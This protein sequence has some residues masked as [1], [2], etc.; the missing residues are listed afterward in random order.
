[1]DAYNK[2][3]EYIDV[4]GVL[5]PIKT[6]FRQSILFESIINDFSLE[7]KD[8][9][10]KALEVY[11]DLLPKG[12]DLNELIEKILWFFNGGKIYESSGSENNKAKFCDFNQDANY[13]VT[14]FLQAYGIDLSTENMHWWRFLSL[15]EGLPE[16]TQYSKIL[17][18]RCM[19]ITKEMSKEQKKHY[20]KMKR[21][22]RLKDTRPQWMID[23]EFSEGFL[24]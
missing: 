15:V 18:Y 9:I 6:D 13:I 22:Y 8:K 1:M 3:P 14:S 17:G 11:F 10:Q 7:P 16:D 5:I 21:L 4:N 20:S 19:E 2:L 12:V 24:L 23:D